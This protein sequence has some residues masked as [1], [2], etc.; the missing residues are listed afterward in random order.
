MAHRPKRTFRQRAAD[1]S[2]S[3]GAEE[4]P[5]EPGAPRELPVPGS[6]EEEPPSGGGRAQVAGLPHRV[7]GPR[8][9]GR[10]WAS[11]RRATKAAPRADEGSESRTLDVSTDEEDKIHHSSESKDD[12]GLSSDSSSS[13]GEKE[14]SSTV[15]IPDAA[16]IQAARRKRELARAQDDYISLDVQH[17]SS[18]SVSRNEETS[19]E[20]QEDEKQDTWEQQQMRKAVKIIEERDIDL[21]CGNGSSK[22]KKFDTSISFPPVNLEIIKK[23]LNTRLTLLQETHRSHLREYEK[24]VQ[25]VKSSKSTIQNLESSSNQALNCKFYKSMKIYVE[26]L[27]DCLNEKIINIQEIE[28]SMHALLLK[29]AMTFMKRR[30][31]ELKHE[32]TYLQ[33]LSRK[34]ETSTSGNFSVDEK[35]Q[36]ILEE[37]ESR[38]TKRRQARVLSGNCNHQEG[39]SSDDELPSAEMIDFQKSQGDI[40]Q[41]QK[42]VFEEVQDDFCNIQNILLKFQQ[43]REKFPD[44]YYEAF[45]SLCIPKLLNPLIRVQLIDWN[46]L[47]L[48]STGLKEMPWFKSVEEFMDSSVEDSKKESSS[49][50]KVLS[51]IINKTIIPRLTDFV[52]FL[53]DPLSTSQTTSLITHCRVILE[54]H[55]TCENEVSKSRQDLLKSIVSRMKKAV[56]DDV[57]IPLYPKSAVENK[58]SPHSKFQ[59]RQFWS[60]L[61][62]FRNI[63]LWNGLLT[64][65]TL[66]ELGLGKLLNR[67][68]IIALLNATPG[69]DVVKKCNQ[70][71]ACLPEKWFENSAMRTSIPQL[72]NFIQFLLQSAH[73]LSRSEFRDEVEEIILILVKIKALNQAESFIGEHHLDHLKSLIKE[74]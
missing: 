26:N 8:G 30:Q 16:F 63:L 29:Q 4:S 33:Q 43:W 19:E 44:S 31:D 50:K 32:S 21:S 38:R 34:D 58:T 3:D 27:I 62:L 28:S 56:E 15:K 1:S 60:G 53:W 9:R 64:D 47:K 20:S 35:T 5:A 71:A 10:V 48:E 24:Y 18:I 66:Q 6:A 67:Y 69:P 72:E 7:R 52:E 17:T 70:V 65:D 74:D 12:Q 23:Q 51:A 42:K 45:I 13:L 11:S 39:T 55:S 2:D 46:P 40:L 22:V 25:D 68:L 37:I 36:W 73:K 61:K 57:F 14:L 54:E 41:K 59:E 49:D